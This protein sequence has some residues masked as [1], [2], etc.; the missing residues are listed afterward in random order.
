MVE[1]KHNLKITESI[2]Q[3][4]MTFADGMSV[5]AALKFIFGIKQDRIAGM[6]IIFDVLKYASE[7]KIN[8]FLFG[9]E[10]KTL[11]NFIEKSNKVYP[12][13]NFSGAISPTFGEISDLDNQNYIN[14]INESN[15]QLVLVCLGCPKQELW[16][17]QNYLKINATLLGI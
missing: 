3:S 1:A 8:L 6:D 9:S 11:D 2:N 13:L 12:N 4:K 17:A 7:K 14:Q 16:M 15:S 5:V 10:Q